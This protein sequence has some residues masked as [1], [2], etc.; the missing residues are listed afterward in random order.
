V[1]FLQD[2]FAAGGGPQWVDHRIGLVK[3]GIWVLL[4]VGVVG[5]LL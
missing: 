5:Q 2:L 1:D 4:A 3:L